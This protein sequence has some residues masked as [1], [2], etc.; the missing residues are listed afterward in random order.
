[1]PNNRPKPFYPIELQSVSASIAVVLLAVIYFVVF[2]SYPLVEG[3]SDSRGRFFVSVLLLPELLVSG[4]FGDGRLPS[5]FFDRLPVLIG[6]A[7]WIGVA[8]MLG[9]AI[10]R[11]VGASE[12]SR[13]ERRLLAIL[14]GLPLLSTVT[15]GVGLAGQLA[16][17]WLLLGCVGVLIGLA[18]VA[19]RYFSGRN[20][21]QLASQILPAV[22]EPAGKSLATRWA[23]KLSVVLVVVL[24]VEYALGVLMPPWEFDVVEYHL[25]APKEF[26]QS[27]S[28][29]F[30]P[31]NI[32]A[33]MPL[34]AEMHALAAMTL[35]S[36]TDAWWIGALI[37][38]TIIGLHSLLA[39]GLL[40]SHVARRWGT[41]QGWLAAGM[42]LACPGHGHVAMAGLI[43]AALGTYILAAVVALNKW[44]CGR[45]FLASI[46]AGAAAACKY[47]GLI[48]AVV[49]LT[50]LVV[51]QAIRLGQYKQFFVWCALVIAGLSL[52]CLPWY[53]KNFALSGNPF[54]PLASNIFGGQ[55]MTEA[56]AEQW[57]SAHRVPVT[58]VAAGNAS[59]SDSPYTLYS[60]IEAME[61]IG[62]RSQNLNPA[63]A[64]L[65]VIAAPICMRGGRIELGWLG[66]SMWMLVVWWFATHRIDRFWLPVIPLWAGVAALGANWL[67]HRISFGAT[68]IVALCGL[69]YG[70]MLIGSPIIGDNRFFVRLS[71]LRADVGVP[72]ELPGRI[73]PAVGWINENLV[74]QETCVGLIGEARVFDFACRTVYATC[75]DRNPVEQLLRG[76]VASQQLDELH[77]AGITHLLVNWTEIN[78]Y[79]SPGN[80]GFSDWPTTTDIQNM[81]DSR[82]LQKVSWSIEDP[83]IQL[84]RVTHDVP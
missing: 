17:R 58:P 19:R 82:V 15:L 65:L 79:R 46:L 21:D 56:K 40:G 49:P 73:S 52:T 66:L 48:Y 83:N 44:D 69:G 39:A 59:S 63:L 41:W 80:Y 45:L 28:I 78:R 38:K 54:Y 16:E 57:A 18:L 1:M 13:A 12:L 27:G 26:H 36:G 43:D 25:Q 47:P 14:V 42:L 77:R 71:A 6:A 64:I 55:T 3:T 70:A 68:T 62:L 4:W 20:T 30:V 75:F 2:M 35:I 61:Q 9:S 23:S 34:A 76:R 72:G 37:G 33:N 51:V 22:G 84:L 60:L 24:A 74:D 50:A 53:A 7:I 29:E 67:S 10:M 31:H 81:L 5:A 11:V 8:G 32:Y